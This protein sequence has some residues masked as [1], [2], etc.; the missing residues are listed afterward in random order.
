MR[1]YSQL[2]DVSEM[3]DSPQ[4]EWSEKG[5]TATVRLMVPWAYRTTLVGEIVGNWQVYPRNPQSGARATSA[6]VVPYPGAL[7]GQLLWTPDATTFEQALVTIKY[8]RDS[9]TPE[10]ADLISEQLSPT[11][12]FLTLDPKDFSWDIA[13]KQPLKEGEAPGLLVRGLEYTVT[14]HK[15]FNIP[16]ACLTLP[17]SVN[18]AAYFSRLLGLSFP[19]ETLLY[20]PP[21]SQRKITANAE[22]PPAWQLTHKLAYKPQGWNRFWNPRTGK[23]D[24]IYRKGV[25]YKNHPP[26]SFAGVLP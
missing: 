10:T 15:V 2:V 18:A 20:S 21:D 23:F 24:K 19:A 17:G 7:T 12:E 11:A 1:M 25:E 26:A 9:Q 8:V 6:T 22:E 3:N 4:E 16:A 14:Q 13:G 5:L